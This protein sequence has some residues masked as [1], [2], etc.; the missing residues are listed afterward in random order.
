MRETGA[1]EI[2]NF[3][4]WYT[5]GGSDERV[6]SGVGEATSSLLWALH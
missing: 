1:V 5:S 3:S 2:G 4:T 6:A